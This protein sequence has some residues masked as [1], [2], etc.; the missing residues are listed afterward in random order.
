MDYCYMLGF[1]SMCIPLNV[2]NYSAYHKLRDHCA[3]TWS[4][5]YNKYLDYTRV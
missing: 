3:Y 1:Q 5:L 4:R 2:N